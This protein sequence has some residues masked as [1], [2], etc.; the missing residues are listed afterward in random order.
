M[1]IAI[2]SDTHDNTPAIVW[3]IEYLNK[4][5]IKI[6]LHAGDMINPGILYRFRDHYEGHLHFVFGN[7]DGEQALA[8]R[9]AN[10]TENI[11]C[12]LLEMREEI[13]GKNLFMNHYSS[14]SESVAKSGEFDVCIGGH[15][16]LYRVNHHDKT[17][18]I[19]P[20]NTVTKD[21]WLPQEPDKES[22]FV[23]LDLEN[24][25]VERVLLPD[26]FQ[27]AK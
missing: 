7:N 19:N 10:L 14:I 22:S 3:I 13:E 24:M 27:Y 9:R 1:K 18:F 26:N 4:N 16:H 17:I 2:L 11:T 15:D 20:G 25:E 12:H 5:G 21:K 6:A 23:I 8:E